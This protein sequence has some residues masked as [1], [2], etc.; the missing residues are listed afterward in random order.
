MKPG[1]LAAYAKKVGPKTVASSSSSRVAN[2]TY[3]PISTGAIRS[4]GNVGH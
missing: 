3:M 1:V 4:V 2:R